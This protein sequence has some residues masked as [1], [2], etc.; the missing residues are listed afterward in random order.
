M[1]IKN[2]LDPDTR[3]EEWS[4]LYCN[5]LTTSELDLVGATEENLITPQDF[6]ILVGV[7]QP[8]IVRSL[9]Q[10][11]TGQCVDLNIS[12]TFGGMNGPLNVVGVSVFTFVLTL[13]DNIAFPDPNDTSLMTGSVTGCI[14]DTAQPTI[15]LPLSGRLYKPFAL[16]VNEVQCEIVIGGNVSVPVATRRADLNLRLQYIRA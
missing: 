11:I 2:L 9:T 8:P 16:A 7:A 6:N 10:E 12:L 5:S 3:L 14:D 1:S 4:S 15:I 13:P